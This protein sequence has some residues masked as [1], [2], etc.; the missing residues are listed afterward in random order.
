[1]SGDLK[2]ELNRFPWLF[3]D[4]GFRIVEHEYERREMGHSLVVLESAPLRL[5]FVKDAGL[6][7]PGIASLSEPEHWMALDLLCKP[8]TGKSHTNRLEWWVSWIRDHFKELSEAVGPK[9]SETKLLH[10][11]LQKFEWE[12]LQRRSE[13]IRDSHEAGGPQ[14]LSRIWKSKLRWL[15]LAAIAIAVWKLFTL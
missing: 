8:L 10:D 2:E 1:M 6:I 7:G 9:F 5:R 12:Q 13:W 15:I 14:W 11:R 3:D 4:L